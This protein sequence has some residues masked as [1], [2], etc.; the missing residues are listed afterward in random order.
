MIAPS[1]VPADVVV[2]GAGIAGLSAALHLAERGLHPLI[3]EAEPRY[4]GGRVAGGD[5]V[6]LDGW[7]FRGDHGVHAI[8]SPYRNLQAM[9]AR[10]AIRPVLVPAQE[11][12]W[13]YKR[14]AWARRAPW[15]TPSAIAGSPRPFT[16]STSL[17]GLA[18][19]PCSISRNTSGCCACGMA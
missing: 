18:S 3:L 8:W 6:E 2:V 16:I 13:V 14:A 1:E 4:V 15:A 19:W 10:H 11:E 9:L 5:V 7:R 17:S 12:D